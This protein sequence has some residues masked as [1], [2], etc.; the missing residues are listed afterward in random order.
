[1]GDYDA[2]SIVSIWDV[3]LEDANNCVG[4]D[5]TNCK[6]KFEHTGLDAIKGMFDGLFDD[7]QTCLDEGTGKLESNE[8]EITEPTDT[9]VASVFLVWECKRKDFL[10]ATDTFVFDGVKIRKQN[11]V[12]EKKKAME[13]LQQP[14]SLSQGL[15]VATDPP[16]PA[17]VEAAWKNHFEA[18]D[19]G[20]KE[21]AKE[22][23]KDFKPALDKIM[24]DYVE[25]SV[26]DIASY[27]KDTE[28]LP[29]VE[30]FKG[31]EAIRG[32]FLNLFKSITD[33]SDLAAPLIQ[34]S[35]DNDGEAKQ[36][37]LVWRIPAS[38]TD[39]ATDT[40]VFDKDNRIIKQNIVVFSKDTA[41]PT[42]TAFVF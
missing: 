22:G 17:T 15:H 2:T 41:T 40:F 30:K 42:N 39:W 7:L 13:F 38:K 29:G 14:V 16:P 26:V 1:M 37:F 18:F 31:K 25:D 3:S 28:G 34:R 20:A 11:I 5:T 24:L 6:P 8:G 33:V 4:G 23:D 36:V 12:I 21:G 9:A 35:G 32:M 10:K 27:Y 19:M